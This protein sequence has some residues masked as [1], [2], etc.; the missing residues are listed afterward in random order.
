MPR[1][2]HKPLIWLSFA[3]L[4]PNVSAQISQ[5]ILKTD[6]QVKQPFNAPEGTTYINPIKFKAA[7][8]R[9]GKDT[10]VLE[11]PFASRFYPDLES[12]PDSLGDQDIRYLLKWQ[13]IPTSE[14]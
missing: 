13:H 8:I 4:C 3:L 10:L 9:K 11:L 2:L 14:N 12:L 6:L 5:Q 7:H 1:I